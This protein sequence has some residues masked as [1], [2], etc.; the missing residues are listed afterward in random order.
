MRERSRIGVILRYVG[1][2][3][4]I[5]GI[6]LVLV[7]FNWPYVVERSETLTLEEDQGL[8]IVEIQY[9]GRAE[10]V[11]VAMSAYPPAWPGWYS[12]SLHNQ[13]QMDHF[14]AYGEF[15]DGLF[16]HTVNQTA[17]YDTSIEGQGTCYIVFGRGNSNDSIVISADVSYEATGTNPYYPVPGIVTFVAGVVLVIVGFITSPVMKYPS[18][19]DIRKR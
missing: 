10:H 16:G 7:L 9:S 17:T 14:N 19:N 18:I 5:I 13:S 12:L 11:T 6:I 1:A 8:S 4:I 2:A 3:S 15:R